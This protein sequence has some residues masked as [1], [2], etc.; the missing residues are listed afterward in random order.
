M[1]TNYLYTSFSLVTF[2]YFVRVVIL[3][4]CMSVH[5]MWLWPQR[6]EEVSAPLK[7]DFQ[8]AVSHCVGVWSQICVP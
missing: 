4:A 1:L 7:L 8:M 2:Y 3:P 5:H 6:P